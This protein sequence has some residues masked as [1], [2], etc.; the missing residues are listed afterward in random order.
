VETAI[1]AKAVIVVKANANSELWAY[2]TI[3][4]LANARC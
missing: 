1:L 4:L 2:V 3:Q